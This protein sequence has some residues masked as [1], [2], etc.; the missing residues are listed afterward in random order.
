MNQII[1]V[2]VDKNFQCFNG[3]YECLRSNK[4]HLINKSIIAIIIINYLHQ[5]R[6]AIHQN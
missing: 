2:K 5:Q 6:T 4:Y 1:H 3:N